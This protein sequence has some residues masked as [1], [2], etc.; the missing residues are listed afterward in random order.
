MSDENIWKHKDGSHK[1]STIKTMADVSIERTYHLKLKTWEMKLI[2]DELC[3]SE[4]IISN[5]L[6]L[7]IRRRNAVAFNQNAKT[8]LRHIHEC[9]NKL[10]ELHNSNEMIQMKLIEW[11]QYQM[12]RSDNDE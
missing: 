1:D 8:S 2:I 4:N 10:E 6:G 9:D 3:N 7:V 5:H 12:N 11:S